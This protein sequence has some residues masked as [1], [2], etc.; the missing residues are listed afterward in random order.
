MANWPDFVFA[1]DYKIHSLQETEKHIKQ[2][3]HL[4]GIPSAEEVK[5]NGIDLGEM[6]AK[7]LEKVEELTLHL[8]EKDKEII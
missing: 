7:L 8:I 2:H 6:N 4:P 1:K 3:G 5:A